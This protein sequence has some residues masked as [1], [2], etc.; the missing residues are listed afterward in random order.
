MRVP[1]GENATECIQLVCPENRSDVLL[2]GCASQTRRVQS[3][4]PET[5]RAP[6]DEIATDLIQLV[7]PRKGP[8]MILPVCV[9]QTRIV[10]S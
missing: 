4:E 2:P 5:I 9:S 8:E 6:S 3:A 1:S 7:C 10:W